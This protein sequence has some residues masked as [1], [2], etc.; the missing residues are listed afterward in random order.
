MCQVPPRLPFLPSG[1]PLRCPPSICIIWHKVQ[2]STPFSYH[3][4]MKKMD[5]V[6]YITLTY[7]VRLEVM[8]FCR[9]DEGGTRNGEVLLEVWQ[10]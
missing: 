8:R 2:K 4:T 9:Q 7:F 10:S 1:S 5:V 6:S 3:H